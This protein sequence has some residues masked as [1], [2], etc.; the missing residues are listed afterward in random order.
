MLR[1]EYIFFVNLNGQINLGVLSYLKEY[2][3]C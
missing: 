2:G 1:C 3:D